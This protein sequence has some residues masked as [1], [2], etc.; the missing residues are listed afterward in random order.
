MHEKLKNNLK[1]AVRCLIFFI[2]L[3]EF[4]LEKKFV[5]KVK[6]KRFEKNLFIKMN[7][8]YNHISL[9][10]FSN[11]SYKS[12][13]LKKKIMLLIKWIFNN[14]IKKIIFT[15]KSGHLSALVNFEGNEI[16]SVLFY[17]TIYLLDSFTPPSMQLLCHLII[18][19]LYS[20]TVTPPFSMQLLCIEAFF[21]SKGRPMEL[22][23]PRLNFNI[24][25]LRHKSIVF[26]TFSTRVGALPYLFFSPQ[27]FFFD[28]RSTY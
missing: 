15:I 14:Y 28:I 4:F 11:V 25:Y 7:M 3:K 2:F 5:Q 6:K 12:I 24:L 22:I 13:F 26:L 9:H 17:F 10:L 20:L 1:Y 19:L 23:M 16:F 18:Y 21:S 27:K 8:R